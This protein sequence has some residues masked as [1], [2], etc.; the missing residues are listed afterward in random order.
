MVSNQASLDKEVKR[1]VKWVIK[2]ASQLSDKE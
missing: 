2:H 1:H